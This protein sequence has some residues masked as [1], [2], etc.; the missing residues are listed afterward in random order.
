LKDSR[1]WLVVVE[2]I[3]V[4]KHEDRYDLTASLAGEEMD[5]V[6]HAPKNGFQRIS[7]HNLRLEHA[8]NGRLKVTAEIDK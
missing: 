1:G 5:P 3:E 8:W 7:I 6:K 2:R 4:K